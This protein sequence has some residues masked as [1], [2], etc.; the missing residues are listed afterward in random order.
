MLNQKNNYLHILDVYRY[1]K[2]EIRLYT[3]FSF[4]NMKKYLF[5]SFFIGFTTISSILYF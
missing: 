2:K 5:T 4:F 3:Y 1:F